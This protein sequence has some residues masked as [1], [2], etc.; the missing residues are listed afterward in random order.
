MYEALTFENVL[1]SWTRRTGTWSGCAALCGRQSS[2]Q[3]VSKVCCVVG[4]FLL[5]DRSLLA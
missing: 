1:C 2:R 4:L 5:H 3:K